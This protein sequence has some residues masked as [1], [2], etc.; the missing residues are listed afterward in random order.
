MDT[1]SHAFWGYA[2]LRWRGPRSARWGLLTGAAPDLLYASAAALHR[3]YTEGWEGL[4]WSGRYDPAIWRRGGPPMPEELQYA[5][6]HFYVYTHSF[7]I[8]GAAALAWCAISRRPPWLLLPWALHIAM[9]TF[10][11]ERYQTPILFPISRWALEGYAWSRPPML[12][13]NFA[14]LALVYALLYRKYWSRSRPPRTQPWPEDL[15]TSAKK[16]L[17]PTAG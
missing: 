8:L 1:L 17:Q 4:R 16:P 6:D 14:A 9:D 12:I 2:S 13:A 15:S 7:V 10:S 5:Y 11:H 3:L